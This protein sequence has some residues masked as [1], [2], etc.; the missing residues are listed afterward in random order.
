LGTSWGTNQLDPCERLDRHVN[1]SRVR[2][3]RLMLALV[4]ALVTLR[5]VRGAVGGLA[6]AGECRSFVVERY[7]F[8]NIADSGADSSLDSCQVVASSVPVRGPTS[9]VQR[10]KRRYLRKGSQYFSGGS[11]Q[12]LFG[13]LL[14]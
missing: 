8:W 9:G 1:L 3:R 6:T 2:S 10:T 4:T 11:F 12:N 7:R 13:R 14:A 5:T